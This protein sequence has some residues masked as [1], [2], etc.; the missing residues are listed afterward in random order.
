MKSELLTADEKSEAM[1]MINQQ[2]DMVMPLA[3][4]QMKRMAPAY[5]ATFLPL[6]EKIAQAFAKA[7]ADEFESRGFF[8]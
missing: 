2:L 3:I 8:A 7:L 1:E 5:E 4:E 6:A